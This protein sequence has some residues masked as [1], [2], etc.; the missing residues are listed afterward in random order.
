MLFYVLIIF[1]I[2]IFLTQI[3]A[4]KINAD[5]TIQ[6]LIEIHNQKR[7]EKGLV[8]LVYNSQLSDSATQKA[9]AMLDSD[10]WSHY[11]PDGKSPWDFFKS[12][13]YL[14]TYAGENLAEGFSTTENVMNAWMNSPTHRDNILNGNYTEIGFGFAYGRYQGKNNNVVVAVH[15]GTPAFPEFAS[16]Q[17]DQSVA[18]EAF[19]SSIQITN[20]QNESILNTS[21]LIISGNV[22]PE[23]SEVIIDV[24]NTEKGRVIA[25]GKNFTYKSPNEYSDGDYLIQ[26]KVKNAFIDISSQTV[27]ITLDG[28][29]P[30][31][32]E[33]TIQTSIHN[34]S[35]FVISLSTTLDV[36]RFDATPL[37][38]QISQTE[39]GNWKIY[40]SN[41]VLDTDKINFKIADTS[42]NQT[43]FFIFTKDLKEKL[44]NNGFDIS[45]SSQSTNVPVNFI[46][47]VADGG[48]Q[49]L[50]PLLFII[51]LLVL[52]VIDYVFLAKTK[53]LGKVSRKPHLAV[54]IFTITFLV[55]SLG[56]ITGSIL[57][58]ISAV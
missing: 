57:N 12:A 58:G 32:F 22:Q 29:K 52:L 8:G 5:I 3:G 10:C 43:E 18:G 19:E 11:C 36:V 42:G 24:N 54:S 14:Y 39:R 25:E 45:V 33:N 7:S 4:F 48:L 26:A 31:I 44:E 17:T 40:F 47:R 16:T 51:Y 6:E 20:P 35:S 41:D 38:F 13:G 27:K 50:I 9:K 46:K 15:F 56:G 21:E 2:N 30:S 23:G 34:E 53:M 1:A 49:T 37:P 28:Q 55:I